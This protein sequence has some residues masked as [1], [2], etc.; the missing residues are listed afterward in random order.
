MTQL[1]S[2]QPGSGC[3][4]SHK[5]ETL[6]ISGYNE[7]RRH[8]AFVFILFLCA[9]RRI[10]IKRRLEDK[11]CDLMENVES[12]QRTSTDR[13]TDINLGAHTRH[14]HIKLHTLCALNFLSAILGP[15]FGWAAPRRTWV[16]FWLSSATHPPASQLDR[17]REKIFL[18]WLLRCEYIPHKL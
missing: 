15:Y 10:N 12:R 13:T 17:E 4:C 11:I 5:N 3:V 2:T 1:N 18:L 6:A 7:P 16:C 8:I 9:Q 14:N